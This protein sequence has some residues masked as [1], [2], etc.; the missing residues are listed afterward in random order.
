MPIQKRTT[1]PKAPERKVREP[2]DLVSE[3]RKNL[4]PLER[5]LKEHNQAAS[6]AAWN[7]DEDME[8]YHTAE[9]DRIRQRIAEGEVWEPLH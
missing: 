7:G 9:A 3:G 6:D 1:L 4:V 8:A 5:L 2:S